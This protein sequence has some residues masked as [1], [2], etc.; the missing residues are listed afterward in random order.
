M[1]EHKVTCPQVRVSTTGG[2]LNVLGEVSDEV[3][4]GVVSI[5]PGWGHG[6]DGTA[7]GSPTADP[8]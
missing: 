6:Q 5:P 7:L 4:P 8:A 1:E 3:R 2:Q